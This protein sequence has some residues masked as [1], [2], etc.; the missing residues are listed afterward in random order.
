MLSTTWTVRPRLE[1]RKRGRTPFQGGY[2][3]ANGRSHVANPPRWL[4]LCVGAYRVPRYGRVVP[5]PLSRCPLA[6][7]RC[8]T[9]SLWGSGAEALRSGTSGAARVRPRSRHGAELAD[10]EDRRKPGNPQ[11]RSGLALC[12]LHRESPVCT[13][14]WVLGELGNDPH[15]YAIARPRRTTLAPS[16]SPAPPAT[17]NWAAPLRQHDRPS[18]P[19][20][21]TLSFVTDCSDD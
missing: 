5:G 2:R 13:G 9:M 14:A 19:P 12:G 3:K 7:W 4:R 17:G 21:V 15:R 1:D 8:R 18:S 16:R 10:G 11:N 6:C 20:G